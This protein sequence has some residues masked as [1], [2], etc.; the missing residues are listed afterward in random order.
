MKPELFDASDI[1][2]TQS[3]WGVIVYAGIILSNAGER[4]RADY[5]FDRVL[6]SIR[7]SE[8]SGIY[9]PGSLKVFIE[10]GRGNKEKAI[11]DL[12]D[13]ADLGWRMQWWTLRAPLFESMREDPRWVAIMGELEADAAR[14]RAWFDEHENDEL[15][16]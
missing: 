12:R 1:S 16:E 5:L 10:V 14:Q 13:A 2:T 9:V 11:E 6:E 3:N 7:S 8:V 15:F 4:S